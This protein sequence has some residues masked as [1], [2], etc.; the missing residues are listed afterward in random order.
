MAKK[1]SFLKFIQYLAES[2]NSASLKTKKSAIL[3]QILHRIY[4]IKFWMDLQFIKLEDILSEKLGNWLS[5]V[6][7]RGRK[8]FSLKTENR[9][10]RTRKQ[11]TQVLL[12]C[13]PVVIQK[14]NIPHI[15]LIKLYRNCFIY[16]YNFTCL[17]I[18]TTY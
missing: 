6:Y 13:F 3:T 8:W 18:E 4:E 10:T 11:G 9:A 14:L 12:I 1:G 5:Y 15:L 17:L 2:Q 7:F 16:Q